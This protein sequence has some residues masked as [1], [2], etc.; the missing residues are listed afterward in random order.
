MT[1]DT[2][3]RP[4]G[5]ELWRRH[6]PPAA[7]AA[8]ISGFAANLVAA[9]LEDELTDEDWSALEA[10]LAADP[11]LVETVRTAAALPPTAAE[12]V[13]AAL[14]ARLL[15]LRPSPASAARSAPA[16]RLPLWRGIAEWAMAAAVLVAVAIAGFD[17]GSATSEQSAEIVASA[18]DDEAAA[19]Q[20]ALDSYI[21]TSSVSFLVEGDGR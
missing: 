18:A 4:E 14:H 10:R 2:Q 15:A 21:P 19:F 8:P 7:D 9:W 16:Q 13:P 20:V 6:R 11:E 12:A 3:K 17:L 1:D 5:R